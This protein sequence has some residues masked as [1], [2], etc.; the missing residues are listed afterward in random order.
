ML[1]DHRP[2]PLRTVLP[3]ALRVTLLEL[4][5]RRRF[6]PARYVRAK[7]T[8]VGAYLARSG[9]RAAVVGVS[10][11]IDS[12]VVLG[13]LRAVAEAPGST[14]R[15]VVG[16][17]APVFAEPGA[18][19]QATALDRGRAVIEAFGAQAVEVDLSGAHAVVGRAV[20]Q[21]MGVVGN[22]WAAGQLV[23][24][25]RTPAF[26]YV[27][28]VLAQ[29]G[30]LAVLC[31]TTNR[32]E[33][34]Y[35]GFFGKASDAMV[36]LQLVSD[37]H[38]S[39]V[40]ALA[41]H[42]G[43]P[44]CVVEATPTGD[45]FDGR[46]DEEMIG[47]P[48]DFVELYTGLRALGDP[49]ERAALEAGWDA[50]ARQAFDGWA[51]AVEEL[52]RVN[53]HKYLA[54]GAAI[55]F[56][57]MPR[58]VPG[59]W[60]GP[61]EATPPR[62]AFVGEFELPSAV[63]ETL[64]EGAGANARAEPVPGFGESLVVVHGLLDPGEPQCLVDV[65]ADLA[66]VAVGTH[67]V[68]RGHDP[69]RDPPGSGRVSTYDHEL[70]AVLW[71]RLAPL[72]PV[73]RIF[74]GTTPTDHDG[75]PV[76]RPM[77]VSPL[78]RF[79][80]YERGGSLVPHHDAGFDYGDGRRRTL[81]SVL[82]SLGPAREPSGG[83]GH[84]R[85]LVDRQRHRP[86]CERDFSDHIEAAPETDAL[87]V[88]PAAPGSAVVFD[89]R[90]LHEGLAWDGD[91]PRLLLRADVVFE[92]CGPV[93]PPPRVPALPLWE[94]LG[95]APGSDPAAVDR[96]YAALRETSQEPAALRFA[97][98]M[99]RDPY[100]ASAYTRLGR[101]RLELDAGFFDDGGELGEP[102]PRA[103]P[104]W[105]CTPLHH[106]SAA[107]RRHA[108]GST[109][110][111]RRLVVL[112]TTGGFAPVHRGHLE[113]MEIA[114][115]TLEQDGDRVL[116]GYLS[117]SHDGYVLSKCGAGCPA[118]AERIRMCEVAVQD[119]DWLMVDP[120]EALHCD[121]AVNFTDVI[122]RLEAYLNAHLRT[123]EPIEVVYVFG[124]DN[125]RFMLAFAE[126]G[127]CVCVPRPGAQ[128]RLAALR[129]HPAL[130]REPRIRVAD[131]QAPALA[132]ARVREGDDRGVEPQV[133]ALWNGA[134]AQESAPVLTRLWVRDE[135]PWP[136]EPWIQGRD[137]AAITGAR[138]R[139]FELLLHEL[140]RAHCA[141]GRHELRLEVIEL[142]TQREQVERL[143]SEGPVLGLDPCVPH[144][145]E[146]EVSRCFE[147]SCDVASEHLV[148]R[149]GAPALEEQL[150][151]VPASARGYLLVD[152]D[153]AT[154]RT[155]AQVRALLDGRVHVRG[156]HALCSLAPDD[157][158]DG[159]R[160]IEELCDARDFLPGA[161]G[162]GLVVR[163]PTGALAR[164]PYL[165]PYVRPARR[166]RFPV[167]HELELS[168]TLWEHAA[169]FF[170]TIEPTLRLR[171]ADPAFGVLTDYLGFSRESSLEAV[172]RWHAERLGPI[173]R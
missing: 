116:A 71:R 126:R 68:A 45:T 22:P 78:F 49:R 144:D 10:G 136:L 46:V 44:R 47:A 74:E 105:M 101:D 97:W 125:A 113:M 43:V 15:R 158:P 9:I 34:S 143:R 162:S 58:H 5:A 130:R 67:G 131:R 134:R 88:A 87:W 70:A 152:D 92:R 19:N 118:A 167:E 124:S 48:Y 102:Q 112:L 14:L 50:E 55:H 146:L 61:P 156:V 85:F 147:L 36:D 171:D 140:R 53:H 2:P 72:L 6:E 108:L 73:V 28:S 7:A 27:T 35:I 4:R 90:L 145:A 81:A 122:A 29:Q 107:L 99:L 172:C 69:Q 24:T 12:A 16:V 40:R 84:T 153:V 123:P 106:A 164:A 91:E 103:E 57:V 160:G 25:I 133:L 165:L 42:L 157:P 155:L 135:G 128:E 56:D 26:Y 86:V 163:L 120:W 141:G 17:L 139:F 13:L 52:H 11:G 151:A 59:G 161:R 64:H 119:S 129:D 3:S 168:R 109:Q 110:G 31:G 54:P 76:W 150:A 95:L 138:A 98:R 80:R 117:V 137:R 83:H 114:R 63:V 20:E 23:S 65:V 115:A 30:E 89:H 77:G 96:A 173:A 159:A 104:S 148:P 149:P 82:V 127:R 38:K 18:T 154:G 66:W 33:G 60:S 75:H 169:A 1:A 166:L 62:G 79:I 94:R 93:L 21:G 170:A 142:R 32:D 100:Y 37:L 51:R 111:A 39:E 121:R 8:L 41:E 132:S